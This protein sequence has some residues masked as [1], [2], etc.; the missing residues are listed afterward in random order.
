MYPKASTDAIDLL[1]KL[2]TFNP[3][4]RL[5][6]DGALEH[7]YV[8]EFR[9]PSSEPVCGAPIKI[10]I[11]DDHKYPIGEYRKTLYA[12]IIKKKKLMNQNLKQSTTTGKL[13]K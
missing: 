1:K 11:D 5:S 10:A 12:D 2:L 4:E 6:A 8:A 9:N 7:P 13:H 3:K